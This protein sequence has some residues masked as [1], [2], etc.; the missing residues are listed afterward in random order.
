MEHRMFSLAEAADVADCSV[1][2]IR[3]AIQDGLVAAVLVE[4]RGDFMIADDELAR[5][6]RRTRHVDPFGHQLKHKVLILGEDLLYAGT[7]KMELQRDPRLDVRYASWG[8]NALLMVDNFG[9]HLFVVDLAPSRAVP[10]D[11]FSAVLSAR[12]ASRAA[13]VA[14]FSMA[15]EFLDSYPAV[16]QRLLALAPDGRGSKAQGLRALTIE[17]LRALGLDA[18]T[19]IFRLHG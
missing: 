12:A 6:L 3:Q 7:L 8:R 4:P 16:K 10:D 11:V 5:F 9:A 15:E 17:C 14:Y 18:P 1:D 2:E 19:K 13:A